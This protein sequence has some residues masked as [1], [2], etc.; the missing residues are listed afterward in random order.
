LLAP[1]VRRTLAPRGCTPV[2]RQRARQRD[3]VSVAG[4]LSLSPVRGKLRLYYRTY[5]R[6]WIN[7]EKSVAFLRQVLRHLPG[8]VIVIWD[9]GNMHHGTPIRRLLARCRRVHLEALPSYAPDLNP[10]EPRWKHV[11]YDELANFAPHGV[12]DLDE[13]VNDTLEKISQNSERLRTFFLSSEL[14][15]PQRLL[16]R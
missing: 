6:Q 1:L 2:L 7:N 9:R 13:V 4:A 8:Q 16:L 3:K 15:P 14:P 10:V 11:K 5:P 12:D